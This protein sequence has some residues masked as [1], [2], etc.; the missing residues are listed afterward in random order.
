[1]SKKSNGSLSYNK[2]AGVLALIA[3]FIAGILGLINFI[4]QLFD[5]KLDL[6]RI[7]SILHLIANICLFIAV[8]MISWQA[9]YSAKLKNKIVWYIIYWIIVICAILG[10]VGFSLHL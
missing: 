9:L 7:G 10:Y 6:G 4:F 3:V 1:M 8:V 5:G 2:V